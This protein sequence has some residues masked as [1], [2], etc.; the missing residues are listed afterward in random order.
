MKIISGQND[1]DD[2]VARTGVDIE[3][4]YVRTERGADVIVHDR[5]RS[6]GPLPEGVRRVLEIIEIRSEGPGAKRAPPAPRTPAAVGMDGHGTAWGGRQ[7]A[8]KGL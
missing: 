2:G 8:R 4:P 7:S 3:T 5:V 1:Y 6:P